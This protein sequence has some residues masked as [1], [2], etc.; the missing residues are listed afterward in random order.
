ML[1]GLSL[2]VLIVV[3]ATVANLLLARAASRQTEMALRLAIG[4]RPGRLVRQLVTESAVLA[5]AAG[6]LG[7]LIAV[8]ARELFPALLPPSP[9]PLAIDTPLDGR[10]VAF[11]V[12]ATVLT[13]LL[14]G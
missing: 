14:V 7:V 4:A 9:L 12:A 3:C 1:L 5:G 10:V 6:G 8:K 11:A 2:L 13:L